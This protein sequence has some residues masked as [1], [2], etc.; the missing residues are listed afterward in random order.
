MDA[1]R[2]ANCTVDTL[3]K[4]SRGLIGPWLEKVGRVR[5]GRVRFKLD[6]KGKSRLSRLS[7]HSAGLV[8]PTIFKLKHLFIMPI[9]SIYHNKEDLTRKES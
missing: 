2:S 1:S 4:L 5:V 7:L 3:D 9:K 8:R 6:L